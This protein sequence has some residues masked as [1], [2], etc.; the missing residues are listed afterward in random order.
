MKKYIKQLAAFAVA[1]VISVGFA[2]NYSVPVE[3][4]TLSQLKSERESLAQKTKDA[5][6]QLEA[7]KDKQASV[8]EEIDAVDQMLNSVQNELDKAESDLAEVQGRLDQAQAELEKATEEKESQMNVFG[9]RIKFFYEQ[10]D[11]GYLDII[12]QAES[13]SDMLTRTQYVQDI[14]AYDN[15]IL[16]NLKKNQAIIEEKNSRNRRRKRTGRRACCNSGR[17]TK[18]SACHNGRKEN[19]SCFL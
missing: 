8:Q 9:K 7:L 13:F 5:K 19:A 1:A 6:A 11:I 2:A 18:R 16:D 15:E 4:K 3:A 17:K 10:G 12:F 14:M